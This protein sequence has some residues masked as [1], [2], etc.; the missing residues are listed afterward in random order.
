MRTIP[1][2]KYPDIEKKYEAGAT[3]AS[4]AQDFNVSLNAVT[5][6]MRKAAIPRRTMKQARNLR[7][8][9]QL[10][11]FQVRTLKNESELIVA[12][13]GIS[14]YWAEGSKSP[15]AR[16]LD[17]ANSDPAMIAYFMK[18]LHTCYKLEPKR[19]RVLLYCYANQN[20]KT[21]I[22][23]WSK[24]TNI[25]ANQFTKPYIRHDYREHGRRMEYGLVHI[26]YADKKLLCD[27]L[28]RIK[29]L[30]GTV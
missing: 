7:F 6:A 23:F 29:R 16:V 25:P 10:P 19:F 11:S 8:D 17:F 12:S 24:L 28:E 18:F 13:V 3:M 20:T 15:N 1:P 5:Y 21:L 30:K 9:Q 14:L 26:R 22:Q 27:I 2:S 4:I